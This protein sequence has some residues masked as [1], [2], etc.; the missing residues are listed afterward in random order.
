MGA[1]PSQS[2]D[3]RMNSEA[4]NVVIIDRTQLDDELLEKC[5]ILRINK[6]F[7]SLMAN[8]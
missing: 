7:K 2:F 5:V 3:E 1:L 8:N 4:I 6:R